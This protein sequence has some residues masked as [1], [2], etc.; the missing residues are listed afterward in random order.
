[1]KIK[2]SPS[3]IVNIV[4]AS[5]FLIAFMWAVLKPTPVAQYKIDHDAFIKDI[6]RE[7]QPI[8]A[9]IKILNDKNG[10]LLTKIDSLKERTPSLKRELA[11]INSKLNTIEDAYNSINYNNVSDSALLKRLSGK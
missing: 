9:H 1:M 3:N 7:M 8:R 10:L 11:R 4:F 6:Q 2:L 5:L